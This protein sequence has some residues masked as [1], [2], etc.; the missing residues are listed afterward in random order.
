M[1]GA[2]SSPSVGGVTLDVTCPG[3]DAPL[4]VTPGGLGVGILPARMPP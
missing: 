4:G 3:R 2:M 1:T